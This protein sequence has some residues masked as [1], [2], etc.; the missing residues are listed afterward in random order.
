[1][2]ISDVHGFFCVRAFVEL[3]RAARTN[4]VLPAAGARPV[5]CA[6]LRGGGE[7]LSGRVSRQGTHTL[8]AR[9]ES[10]MSKHA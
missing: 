4:A 2:Q 9:N 7:L 10:A 3:A 1:M 8:R 6:T 5:L